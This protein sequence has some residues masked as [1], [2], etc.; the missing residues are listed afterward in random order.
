MNVFE[1]AEQICG[2]LELG[3]ML[4][5]K[6]PYAWRHEAE[7]VRLHLNCA[8]D[9]HRLAMSIRMVKIDLVAVG[10]R[11]RYQ[12]ARDFHWRQRKAAIRRLHEAECDYANVMSS[13]NVRAMLDKAADDVEHWVANAEECNALRGKVEDE[14]HAIRQESKAWKDILEKV[15]GCDALFEVFEPMHASLLRYRADP[16][17]E[18]ARR[19]AEHAVLVEDLKRPD[20]KTVGALDG[21]REQYDD[22]EMLNGGAP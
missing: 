18:T 3:D 10:D 4:M 15:V 16:V 19:D 2:G 6:R 12:Q 11:E 8:V 9:Q 17:A 20:H 1:A 5:P 7:R 13:T 22:W 14:N 21:T